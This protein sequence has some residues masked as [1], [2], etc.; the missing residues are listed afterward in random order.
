VM[1]RAGRVHCPIVC[2]RLETGCA[3]LP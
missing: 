3:P 2:E 1:H